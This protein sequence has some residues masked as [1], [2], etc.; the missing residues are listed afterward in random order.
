MH[1]YN[2]VELIMNSRT[3]GIVFFAPHIR[4]PCQDLTDQTDA[5]KSNRY[6]QYKHNEVNHNVNS[7]LTEFRQMNMINN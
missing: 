5:K 7:F 1:L 2:T 6:E 4:L 3:R